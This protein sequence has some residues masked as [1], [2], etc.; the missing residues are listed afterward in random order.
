MTLKLKISK[1]IADKIRDK[2]GVSRKDVYE[3][4]ENRRG[5]DL[6]DTRAEH[7]TD[8][9]TRWFLAY[10]NHKRLLKVVFIP[11][12]GW[13]EIKSVF[14]PNAEEIRIYDKYGLDH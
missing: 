2:H 9:L 8:P 11:V 4:F 14:E 6:F 12:D 13:M 7:L 10:T 3:C 5:K 1:R